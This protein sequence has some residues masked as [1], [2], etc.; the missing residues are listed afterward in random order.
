MF[1]IAKKLYFK[2][3]I[4][5]SLKE[6]YCLAKWT[7]LVEE[8]SLNCAIEKDPETPF[9]LCSCEVSTKPQNSKTSS[10]G[11]KSSLKWVP[12]LHCIVGFLS[13]KFKIEP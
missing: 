10:K 8:F 11:K 9:L 5:Y 2:E 6:E 4:C 3:N 13:S 7:L 12:I 1:V